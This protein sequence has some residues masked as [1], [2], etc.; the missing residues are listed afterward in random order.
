MD[1]PLSNIPPAELVMPYR[2]LQKADGKYYPQLFEKCFGNRRD[3]DRGYDHE[4]AARKFLR[5]QAANRV[6]ISETYYKRNGSYPDHPYT[7]YEKQWLEN[8]DSAPLVVEDAAPVEEVKKKFRSNPMQMKYIVVKSED[9]RGNI[10]ELPVMFPYALVHKEMKECVWRSLMDAEHRFIEVVGAGF[11]T[12]ENSRVK[13]YGESE[14]L[15]IRSRGVLDTQAFERCERSETSTIV[16][17]S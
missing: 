15:G 12:V 4:D 17:K 8:I 9:Y 13:C 2:I 16:E 1:K 10:H 14:S 6:L 3:G 11:C 7:Q 5:K